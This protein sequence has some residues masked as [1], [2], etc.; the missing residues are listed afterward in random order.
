MSLSDSTMLVLGN[1]SLYL[2]FLRIYIYS[3]LVMTTTTS[4]REQS[5]AGQVYVYQ[6]E[7]CHLVGH[8]V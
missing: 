1:L 8:E 3:S 7:D 4:W 6:A 5:G 2:T